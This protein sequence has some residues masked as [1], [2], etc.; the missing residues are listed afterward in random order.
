MANLKRT[1]LG[2]E[3]GASEIRM[4]EMRGSGSQ[5]HVLLRAVE[6][7]IAQGYRLVTEK[8]G[9]QMLALEPITLALF[10]AAYPVLEAEPAAL[11]LS[12]T[13]Q[14]SEL[15]ILDHGQIRLYRR[16]E[17]GSNDFI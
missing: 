15:S 2:I 8:A 6:D 13:P 12:V 1:V 4:V 16:L 10:R 5:P 9:L 7:R 11:C 17:M 3:I 14:R